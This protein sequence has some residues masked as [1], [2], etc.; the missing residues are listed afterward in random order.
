MLGL[1]IA[2]IVVDHARRI[3]GRIEYNG[4]DPE[5]E[6]LQ[7]KEIGTLTGVKCSDPYRKRDDGH[8]NM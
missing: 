7:S 8:L 5:A 4:E 2:V 1:D 3:F 6:V